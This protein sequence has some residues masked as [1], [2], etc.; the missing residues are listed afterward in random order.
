[1]RRLLPDFWASLR[2][3]GGWRFVLP[4][5]VALL[6]VV[7]LPRS[8]WGTGPTNVSGTISSNTT[9]TAANSPYVMT[10][11]VTV[12][13]GVTLTIEPGVT[14]QGNASSRELIVS[15]TLSAVGTSAAHI[16]FT[17]TTDT[18]SGQWLRIRFNSGSGSSALTFAD[19]R[20]GGGT[21]LNVDTNGMVEV[22]GGSVTIE[23]STIRESAISGVKVAGGT[24]GTGASLTLRRTKLEHNGWVG[25]TK[26]GDGLNVN[27]ARVVIEDSAFWSNANDGMD[28]TIGT[29]Y[30]PAPGE[31]TGSS[32]WNNVRYGIFVNPSAGKEASSPDGHVA[33]KPGNEIYDNGTFGYGSLEK[34]TQLQV[35]RSSLSVDWS[36]TYWGP[37][38]FAS[39]TLGS[40][41]GHVH[42]GAPDPDP[43]SAIPSPRGPVSFAKSVSGPSWCANDDIVVN[44][45]QATLPDLYFDAPPPIFG[46][47]LLSQTDGCLK[48]LIR[49]P[50]MGMAFD[51]RGDPP[52]THTG[53]PVDTASGSL[54]EVAT[55]LKLAGP[56]ILFAWTRTYNS[57]DT[58]A[59]PLGPGWSHP[60]RASI[61]VVDT[62][63]GELEY[64]AGSGQRNRFTKVSGGST[65]AATYR[66]KGF[67][68]TM[69]RLSD[70][71]Y[72]LTTRD[73]RAFSF[74]S[75]GS[76]TQIKPRFEAATTVAYTSGKLSSITDAAGRTV[77]IT[78]LTSDPSLIEKV[79]L[80]DGRYVQY[81][82][83]SGRLTSVRDPRG[84][85]STLSYDA[86]GRLTA[87][88]DARS[89]Y[90]LQNVV[91]DAQGRV[92]SEQ[93][94]SGDTTSYAYS[95]VSPF[96]V[97]TVTAPDEGD[98]MYRHRGNMLFSVADPLGNTN[99]YTYDWQGRMA[100]VTNPRG[101]TTRFEY[102]SFGNQT[103]EIGP[104]PSG[105]TVERTFNATNDLLTE[106]DGRGNTTT[107][108]FASS[109][110]GDYQAGQLQTVT[111]RENG[112]TTFKYWTSTST[113]TPPSSNVGLLKSTTDQRSK[114]TG[115]AYD[116][117]GN[118][119][120]ITSPLGLKTTMT[121]DGSG[122]LSSRRDPRGN[123][124]V[125]PAGYLTQ[126]TY[127]DADNL[128]TL[129]DAR[130]NVTSYDYYDNE[131]LWKVTRTDRGSVARVTSFDYDSS[132]RLYTT[133]DPRSG[134]ETRLYWADDQLKSVQSPEG[135]KTTYDYDA[136]SRLTT[137]VEPNGNVTGATASDWT[138]TYG[139]D[140]AGNRTSEAHPDG[141]TTA[142]DYDELDRPV[143]WTDP[144]SHV[145]SVE[146]DANDNVTKR[147]DA[148]THFRT[149]VYDKLDRQ[150]S[151]TW[152]SPASVDM[153]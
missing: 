150:T 38:S 44:P 36:G 32:V 146:Y 143:E 6:V 144:L 91:Y 46:G 99:S 133:T 41:N 51:A 109:S 110:N 7:V 123:V 12:A 101:N 33:G 42:F 80:P 54:T 121:Y 117:A 9:W 131:Q 86:N 17:S 118:L 95:T 1:M 10:G 40:Q 137:I 82:Y 11:N 53:M 102:D 72:K 52:T 149:Y 34:W 124:P 66:G 77:T 122:R 116:S 114:T 88:Q 74:D 92:T 76:L 120:T 2:V 28:I 129:T 69:Q 15:G 43:S 56:G 45:A 5:L 113:H 19:I 29:G 27:N 64:R 132:N 105:Y 126:W 103:K 14:V 21:A 128:S 84:K 112:V 22:N 107:Y 96:D 98:W 49:N 97:T 140:A 87:I 31:I 58:A 153:F 62:S 37:T 111:D 90:E 142:I 141:G 4:A 138:W 135:R 94:G 59:G 152:S 125:P 24:S 47:I 61:T 25:T 71:S 39:C 18:A 70:N 68:G 148:L 55:D 127:D 108:A 35:Q 85:T 130:G 145:S 63:T 151:E 93:S 26:H 75:S 147:T 8:A 104:S 136:A 139:Y 16:V 83:T 57:T 100:T 115:Y 73:Q 23:D 30:S 20:N 81:A 67:D 48:C 119:T 134:V 50:S 13:S 89:H 79:T 65:G 78:Y 106:K 60:Y 3:G